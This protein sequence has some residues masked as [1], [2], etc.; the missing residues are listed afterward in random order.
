MATQCLN[1]SKS[2][3]E[4]EIFPDDAVELINKYT[5]KTATGY[6]TKC[7]RKEY[8]DS[9]DKINKEKGTWES[10]FKKNL[11]S[12]PTLTL[13]IPLNWDYDALGIVSGQIT[14]GMGLGGDLSATFANLT[15]GQS[16]DYNQKIMTGET[17]CLN[18]IRLRA[19]QLGGNAVIGVTL[20][21]STAGG[22]KEL[23]L[24][25]AVG[26]AIKLKNLEVLGE[27]VKTALE[28]VTKKSEEFVPLL[29]YKTYKV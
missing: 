3:L 7:A 13:Q 10:Y 26:T 4:H 15:G 23:L 8:L 1:C 28:E 2:V 6:C 29:K 20:N 12:I 27:H 22:A 21:Y 5:A 11:H 17:M 9:L 16:S 25:T 24:V 18:Q 19:L 14:M